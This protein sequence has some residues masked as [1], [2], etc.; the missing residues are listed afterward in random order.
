M[1]LDRMERSF[2]LAIWMKLS[3]E[4]QAEIIEQLK[5]ALEEQ[6]R[7]K[8]LLHSIAFGNLKLIVPEKPTGKTPNTGLKD[9]ATA[10]GM[11]PEA[12]KR[13]SESS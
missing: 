6:E 4:G 11:L 13:K 12:L 5:S 1:K 3:K 8:V 10:L 9:F 2:G 7:I